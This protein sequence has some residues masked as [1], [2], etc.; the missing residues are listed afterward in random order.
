VICYRLI[1]DWI[2]I[3]IF[4]GKKNT[5][6]YLKMRSKQLL[7][8]LIVPFLS[9]SQTLK[10]K[11]LDAVTNQPIASV[12][13]YF[14]NTTVGTTTDENGEFSIEYANASQAILIISYLGY[15][16]VTINKPEQRNVELIKLS[17]KTEDLE[18][19]IIETDPFTRQRKEAY[20]RYYFLGKT[21][22]TEHCEI[23]N[24]EDVDL[25]FSPSQAI[26]FARADK[27]IYVE[28]KKLG[29]RI[30]IDLEKYDLTF[31]KLNYGGLKFSLDPILIQSRYR[32][33]YSELNSDKDPSKRKQKLRDDIYEKSVMFFYRA[34][35]RQTLT[36][37]GYKLYYDSKEVKPKDHIRVNKIGHLFSV[38]FKF[39]AYGLN[40]K[41]D[42]F[43]AI[44]PTQSLATINKNGYLV[45]ENWNITTTK[46]LA[47]RGYFNKLGIS[48]SV[49]DDFECSSC[50]E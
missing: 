27:P 30:R 22:M 47:T 26:L 36:E 8:F 50:S 45:D 40:D 41:W 33:F 29:Y 28:H 38:A 24:I 13:V 37:N 7:V 42:N 1:I 46:L 6:K 4:S 48:A 19:V 5:T 10:G 2:K 20:F 9:I 3:S 34:L 21:E 39:G 14:D 23:L 17:P 16:Q 12:N 18:A 15:Q 35:V 43:T 11:V 31:N 44:A 25:K 49:P 32:T